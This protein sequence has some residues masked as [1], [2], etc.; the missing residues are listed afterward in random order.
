[1]DENFGQNQDKLCKTFERV[2]P[3]RKKKTHYCVGFFLFLSK[4]KPCIKRSLPKI[5]L[6]LTTSSDNAN[7]QNKDIFLHVAIYQPRWWCV[8]LVV[9]FACP[10]LFS[11]KKLFPEPQEKKREKPIPFKGQLCGY[12]VGDVT[13]NDVDNTYHQ[14]MT[15]TILTINQ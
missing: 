14:S 8:R 6:S 4:R 9:H 1:M 11:G 3:R 15:L 5:F 7:S 2:L 10:V 13:I 12:C